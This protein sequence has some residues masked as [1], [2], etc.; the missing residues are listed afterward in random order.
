MK[1]LL[2]STMVLA[3]A[4]LIQY[5]A[6]AD[7]RDKGE[8]GNDKLTIAVFGDWPYNQNLLTNAPLLINSVNADR[9]V[10]LVI[11]VGD[12][13]PC[14]QPCTSAGVL[15]PIP[16]YSGSQLEPSGVFPVSSNSRSQV[17]Y[18]PGDNE[19]TDCHKTGEFKS[20]DPLKEL[21]FGPVPAAVLCKAR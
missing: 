3:T 8:R 1:K 2:T 6:L 16:G 19:W 10:S 17:V 21:K 7:D 11:H 5:S 20:G 12:I 18:T 9:D 13:H 14:S 15:P 4:V